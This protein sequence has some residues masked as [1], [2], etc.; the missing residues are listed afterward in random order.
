MCGL[1][2]YIGIQDEKLR[3]RLVVS[4]GIGIDSRG[5][6]AIGFTSVGETVRYGRQL[7][8]WA[9][10]KAKFFMAAASGQTTM[11]HSRYKT[12]GANTEKNAH[13]YCIKR[14][15]RTILWG[16]H[17]GVIPE[18][19]K[20]A[21]RHDRKFSV[22]SREF[23]ELLADQEFEK[24]QN[25]EGY[26][27]AT[28]ISAEKDRRQ[29][30]NISR[31]SDDGAIHLIAIKGGGFIYASTRDILDN[32]LE[33][34]EIEEESWFEFQTGQTL[35]VAPND[36][37]NGWSGIHL[38]KYEYKSKYSRYIYEG[39]D[40]PDSNQYAAWGFNQERE[41]AS[42]RNLVYDYARDGDFWPWYKKTYPND[43]WNIMYATPE[44]LG[45]GHK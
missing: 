23:F 15:N 10:A 25:M 12:I 27:V 35:I 28:W 16:A 29:M 6:D 13:P 38:K 2:G 40:D 42:Q 32:A 24:I 26:G 37:Y 5:K 33:F 43:D 34:C 7:G 45:S 21:E 19:R 36:V 30:I 1:A 20:S 31:L 22:D 8:E 44:N 4:L 39:D 3:Y 11:M 17:N 9:D 18:A 41:I 14:D